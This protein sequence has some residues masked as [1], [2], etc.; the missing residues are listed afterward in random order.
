MK[1]FSVFVNAKALTLTM[2][3]LALVLGLAFVACATSGGT[4]AASPAASALASALG[5][6]ATA[7]LSNGQHGSTVT[8]SG[9][10]RVEGD[11]P[12]PS[13]DTT[14]NGNGTIYL[15]GKGSLFNIGN[16]QKLILDGVTLVGAADN[17]S[18]LVRVGSGGELVLKSGA[19]IGNNAINS[20]G[21]GVF[22][23]DGGTFTM[24]GGG[25]Y[26]NTASSNGGGIW[27]HGGTFIMEGGE[28]YGN[29]ALNIEDPSGGGGIFIT[30]SATFIMEGGTIYGSDAEGGKANANNS[31]TSSAAITI[32]PEVTAK[33]G[34]GGTYTIGGVPQSGGTNILQLDEYG[35][36]SNVTLIAIPA[37]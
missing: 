27:V 3:A 23:A 29:T 9:D 32:Y 34:T 35:G 6:N 10:A 4:T 2:P 16:G 7:T 17:D 22:V 24:S 28:I 11:L 8:L 12:L 19:I 31:F 14:I 37:R 13:G 20:N 1:K 36:R 21:G 33:W 26:G 30:G 25:I 18:T 15:Q 5:G